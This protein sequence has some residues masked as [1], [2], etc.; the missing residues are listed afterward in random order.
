MEGQD[1]VEKIARV[2]RDSNDK[3]RTPVAMRLVPIRRVGPA[4]AA[5]ARK[6]GLVKKSKS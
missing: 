3:P 4:P 1:V 6:T 2:P 5:P